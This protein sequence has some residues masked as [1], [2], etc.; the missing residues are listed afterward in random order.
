MRSLDPNPAHRLLP[1][2]CRVEASGMRMLVG[3]ADDLPWGGGGSSRF[4]SD[5]HLLRLI[6]ALGGRESDAAGFH[7]NSLWRSLTD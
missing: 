4:L 2:A 1:G 3:T 5:G 7:S 6:G